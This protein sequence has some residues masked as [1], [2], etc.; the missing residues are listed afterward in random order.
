MSIEIFYL[1][2]TVVDLWYNLETEKKLKKKKQKIRVQCDLDI[3]VNP[4]IQM[5]TITL[6]KFKIELF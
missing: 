4:H 3:K 1:Q 6:E 5:Y 2:K